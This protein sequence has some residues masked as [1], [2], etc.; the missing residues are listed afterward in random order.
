MSTASPTVVVMTRAARP[1]ATKTRLHPLLG[2][3]GCA[4]LQQALLAHTVATASQVAATSLH[5]AVEPPDAVAEVA[6]LVGAAAT[7]FDQQGSDLG[8][9]MCT[10][11]AH[12]A[13]AL[14]GPIVLIG[15]DVPLLTSERI[16]EATELLDAGHDV[17][18]GP[19]L[20]GGYYLIALRRPTPAVFDI[21]PALWGGPRVLESSIAAAR[22]AGLDV[23]CLP[24][25][26]D[27]DTPEDARALVAGAALPPAIHTILTASFERPSEHSRAQSCERA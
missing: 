24:V 8:A 23:A 4:E 20:D 19:A 3:A 16:I 27:L 21:D 12:V 9:R 17:V 25:L 14:P 13:A 6:R 11:M 5:V 2:A 10:A 22:A 1:G 15:T 26:R 7:V 18:F